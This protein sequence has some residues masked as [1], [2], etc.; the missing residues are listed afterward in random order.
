M[1]E[2]GGVQW[3]ERERVGQSFLSSL[4]LLFLKGE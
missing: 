4:F 1:R 2:E 3:R